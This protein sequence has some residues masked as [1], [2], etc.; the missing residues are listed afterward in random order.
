MLD[1]NQIQKLL[2]VLCYCPVKMMCHVY[3]YLKSCSSKVL[4]NIAYCLMLQI[5]AF[6]H[7]F[8]CCVLCHLLKISVGFLTN[9]QSWQYWHY[10]QLC[11]PTYLQFSSLFVPYRIN[12]CENLYQWVY[13]NY[14]S[15]LQ[16]SSV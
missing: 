1:E 7:S 5:S 8:K 15:K 2:N 6:G 4:F 16:T 12:K 14:I 13:M 10:C 11:N 9:V 3:F